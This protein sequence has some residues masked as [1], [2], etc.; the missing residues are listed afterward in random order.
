MSAK[1]R[2]LA[3][4]VSLLTLTAFS[5]PVMESDARRAAESFVTNDSL[6]SAVLAGRS[7]DGIWQRGHLWIVALQPSGHLILSA[8][9]LAEPIVG[10]SENDFTEPDP[11]SP[12]YAVLEAASDRIA[13]LEDDAATERDPQW[14]ALLH[15]TTRRLLGASPVANPTT[16]IIPPLL[17]SHYNQCQPYNDFSPLY[18]PN[19]NNVFSYRGRCPCGCV[20]TA[21]AAEMHYYRWP[22]RSDYSISNNHTVTTSSGTSE[23]PLRFD[24]HTPIDWDKINDN[25]IPYYYYTNWVDA[26]SW[27]GWWTESELRGTVP[28][29]NRFPIARLILWADL[30]AKM[31][32]GSGSS[33]ANF[34]TVASSL[35]DWYT[36]GEWIYSSFESVTNCLK[37]GIPCQASIAKYVSGVRSSGHQVIF[38]GWAQGGSVKLVHINY[39]WGGDNDG[40]Y[41]ISKTFSDSSGEYT[42][43]KFYANHF[44]RA[45]P[46]LAPLPTICPTSLTLNW[47]FPDFHTNKLSGFTVS[48]QKMGTTPTTFSDNFSNSTGIS[49][50][51]AQIYVGTD[52]DYTLDGNLL[53]AKSLASGYWTYPNAYTLTS[54]SVL[55]FKILSFAA[56]GMICEVQAKTTNGEWQTICTPSLKTSWG[57]SGWSTERVYLGGMGGQSVN[58]RVAFMFK[59]GSS[60]YS[61]GR[62]LIDDFQITSV[63]APQDPQTIGVGKTARS[64]TLTDL[65]AG[66]DYTFTVTPVISGALVDGETS[67]PLTVTIAGT[68][69]TPTPGQQTYTTT[70]SPIFSTSDSSGVWSYS[71]HNQGYREITKDSISD[72]CWAYVSA[73]L[74]AD[75]EITTSSIVSF[76]YKANNDYSQGHDIFSV[77]P[78]KPFAVLICHDHLKKSVALIRFGVWEKSLSRICQK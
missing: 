38:D 7:V 70:N 53:Y 45:K 57:S 58:L 32:F 31:S 73:N 4:F 48:A 33:Y 67:D 5:A 22:A 24:G 35:S 2:I 6:G 14:D 49:S 72:I 50:S 8:S 62:I 64:V 44:P 76:R 59:N 55:T 25:Y 9:D 28:E 66:A 51:T 29:T 13:H 37:K 75:H 52:S 17:S 20:A 46:Q 30:L 43:E 18:E 41:D 11:E 3:A 19:T 26:T 65:T 16:I 39:G 15:P 34:D 42:L 10:F 60:Y 61:A 1:N 40:Y 74:P 27:S 71:S 54:A 47:H 63:L 23:F 69:S 68:H 77:I 78:H 36:D 56:L 21:T 12:A